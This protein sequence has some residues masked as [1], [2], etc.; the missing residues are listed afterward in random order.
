MERAPK[1]AQRAAVRL[2][3]QTP[4]D[5]IYLETVAAECAVADQSAGR[6]AGSARSFLDSMADGVPPAANPRDLSEGQRLALVL[7]LQ[8]TARAP[9]LLLDEPTRGLDYGA[10]A[11]LANT[12]RALADDGLTICVATHDVE[13]AAGVAD[14]VG[15]MAAGEIVAEG[16][17]EEVMVASTVFTPQVAKVLGLP[18]LLT[19]DRVAA[20]LGL[21]SSAGSKQPGGA[22]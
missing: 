11:A 20:A 22:P 10:K 12:L 18:G 17:A 13:F 7:A 3:P 8:L 9:V 14:R 1:A 4:S 2:V 16:P 6:P 19:P 15:V 21:E 5:L